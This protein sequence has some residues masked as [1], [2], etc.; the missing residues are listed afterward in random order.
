MYAISR[1]GFTL[2][3]LLVVIAIIAILA[4]VVVLTLNPAELLRQSRDSNRLS[5]LSTLVRAI[6]LY[7]EDLSTGSLGSASTTYISVPDANAS[8]TAGDACQ[9]L[10]MPTSTT[11]HCAS[12]TY[13]RQVNSN[14]WLPINFTTMSTG[15]PLGSLPIDPTNQTSSGLYY[16]YATNGTV[17]ELSAIPE[18]Q[19]YTALAIAN[20]TMFTAGSNTSLLTAGGIA[21]GSVSQANMELSIASNTAFADFNAAGT[22]TPYIGDE[23]IITDSSGHQLVGYIKAVGT[24][25][26][27]GSQLMPDPGMDNISYFPVYNATDTIL[28]SGC[29]SGDCLQVTPT[30]A[31]SAAWETTYSAS[32]GMLLKVSVYAK[33]GTETSNLLWGL[34]NGAAS[35]LYFNDYIGAPSSWTLEVGN[36]TVSSSDTSV[37]M[38]FANQTVNKT[39]LWNLASITQ[40]LT[41]S[42]TGVTIVSASGGSSYNWTSEQ[43]GFNRDDTNYTY[44]IVL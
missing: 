13:Y 30:T 36:L 12:S 31:W 5:D 17:F 38:D 1:K 14:G 27:Y 7:Q 11:W 15:A 23:L 28:T 4:V 25:Q 44:S 35:I 34:M 41:P 22:L 37:R 8:T 40:I 33:V 42:T 26:T 3:E 20:P 19:K 43:S 9:A 39:S 16:S 29:Y 10:G 2:I 18:S 21:N 6:G 24:G 32:S